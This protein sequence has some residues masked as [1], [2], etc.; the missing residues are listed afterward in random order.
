MLIRIVLYLVVISIVLCLIVLIYLSIEVGFQEAL[1]FVVVLMVASIPM[2]VEIVTTTTLAVGSKELSKHGAIVCQLASI[3]DLAGMSILCSDK[4]GT[5]TLNMMEIQ[6]ET[7]VYYPDQTQYT[8]LR[9]A[10]MAAKWKEP[11]RDALDR[12][13][14]GS[15]DLPSLDCMTQEEYLP[16]D[17]ITKR[18]EGSLLNTETGERFKCSKG[19]P[20]IIL[21]L[22]VDGKGCDPELAA[23]VE[24]HVQELGSRG[25]RSIA[26]AKT[27]SKGTWRMLGLLTFL[28]PPRPDT[29]DTIDRARAF[30]VAVKMITGDHLLIARETA[31]MLGKIQ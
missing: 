27:D 20:H 4:T 31:R 9:Y 2:A 6:D 10:A 14:L 5:L 22:V 28:D 29:K 8:L 16:F 17:P 25:I 18:T 7:P 12:L 3:E 13:T 21:R 30:G 15:V 11:A 24:N 19:A 26:V 1:G 23:K